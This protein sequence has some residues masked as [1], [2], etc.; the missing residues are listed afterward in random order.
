LDFKFIYK[1]IRE[2]SKLSY[3][4]FMFEISKEYIV[5]VLN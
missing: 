4:N 1:F 3:P 5:Y 2:S